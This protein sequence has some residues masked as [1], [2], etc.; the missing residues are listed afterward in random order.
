MFEETERLEQLKL[1]TDR[2]LAK[3][4]LVIS[5]YHVIRTTNWIICQG[6]K[7]VTVA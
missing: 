2:T 7:K 1:N 4:D 5:H 3:L 6:Y